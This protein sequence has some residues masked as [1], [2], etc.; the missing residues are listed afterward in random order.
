MSKILQKLK[1]FFET[2]Q[3]SQQSQLEAFITSK[4]PTNAA[5]VE[6]WTREYETE[7]KYWGRG[8]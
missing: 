6:Y 8:L 4:R 2:S 7:G 5:E 1:K 3:Q